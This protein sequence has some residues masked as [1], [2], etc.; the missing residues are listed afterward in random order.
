MS[1]VIPF[2]EIIYYEQNYVYDDA[3]LS[4]DLCLQNRIVSTPSGSKQTLHI[5]VGGGELVGSLG[6]E[7]AAPDLPVFPGDVS[8][9]REAPPIGYVEKVGTAIQQDAGDAEPRLG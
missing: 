1:V 8:Q 2:V 3:V 6:I 9:R 4:I 5:I 7:E